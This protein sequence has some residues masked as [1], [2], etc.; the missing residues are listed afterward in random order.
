MFYLRIAVR[1]FSRIS[2][3]ASRDN[4]RKTKIPPTR[5]IRAYC[6]VVSLRLSFVPL[7][8]S[9][10]LPV[11]DRIDRGASLPD[12]STSLETTAEWIDYNTFNDSPPKRCRAFPF[13]DYPFIRGR[14]FVY[15][16]TRVEYPQDNT[17]AHLFSSGNSR[18]SP[19]TPLS[20]IE[21][22]LHM[23]RDTTPRGR[24]GRGTGSIQLSETK[25]FNARGRSRSKRHVCGSWHRLIDIER[26]TV[27]RL[28]R[29]IY[30]AWIP[31]CVFAVRRA[32]LFYFTLEERG[33][34]T[35]GGTGWLTGLFPSFF[36]TDFIV[37]M[38]VDISDSVIRSIEYKI[39]GHR[40]D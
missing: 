27:S 26:D 33:G 38:R 5:Y 32:W 16:S 6:R 4:F 21:A 3:L 30:L 20:L 24:R 37:W 19:S 29:R 11:D 35:F 12:C 34:G 1:N 7:V 23:H 40:E 28:L 14:W 2:S 10:I 13:Q 8:H 15:G 18:F 22:K 9:S 25:L 36:E 31:R 17:R 39:D